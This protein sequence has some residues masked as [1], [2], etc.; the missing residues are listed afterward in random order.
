MNQ[1]PSLDEQYLDFTEKSSPVF[2]QYPQLEP[3]RYIVFRELFA[4]HKGA[5][6]KDI[7]KHW[8]RPLVR[9]S[10]SQGPLNRAD[11]L[12][13]LEGDRAGMEMWLPICRELASRQINVQVVYFSRRDDL[14]VS[15]LAFDFASRAVIPAWAKDAWNDFCQVLEDLR[16]RSIQRSFYHACSYVQ[17]LLDEL[18]RILVLVTPKIVITASTQLMGGAALMIASQSRGAL[19]L[20]LQHGILQP[21]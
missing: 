10:C 19:R 21:F 16:S 11:V 2:A 12:L 5:G 1:V 13:W 3:L 17:G 15:G 4:Q 9:R 20:L 7:A 6:W 8:L 14:P 18:Q